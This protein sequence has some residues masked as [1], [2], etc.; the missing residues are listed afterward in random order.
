MTSIADSDDDPVD[1]WLAHLLPVELGFAEAHLVLFRAVL[2][3]TSSVMLYPSS[4]GTVVLLSAL[5]LLLVRP[6]VACLICSACFDDARLLGCL[7]RLYRGNPIV[8]PL[9][10]VVGVALALG[11]GF[12]VVEFKLAIFVPVSAMSSS[13]VL[14]SPT[15]IGLLV[16]SF[17]ALVA[18]ALL[19]AI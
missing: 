5:I 15:F 8:F 1:L 7:P 14:V 10:F 9:S 6:V 4:S 2:A 11:R 19:R 13:W 18:M 3:R 16:L 12:S 17:D